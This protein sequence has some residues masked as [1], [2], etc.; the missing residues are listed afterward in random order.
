M[1]DRQKENRKS[2]WEILTRVHD[3]KWAIIIVMRSHIYI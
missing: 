2:L 1:F 3:P